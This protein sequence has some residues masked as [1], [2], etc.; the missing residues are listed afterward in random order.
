MSSLNNFER[1][2]IVGTIIGS[3]F[4]FYLLAVDTNPAAPIRAWFIVLGWILLAPASRMIKRKNT[5][6]ALWFSLLIVQSISMSSWYFTKS[7]IVRTAT[8]SFS[9][10]VSMLI[11]AGMIV[12]L[13]RQNVKSPK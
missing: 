10:L 4:G 12:L 7:S 11:V 6:L 5:Y 8:D 3:L 13:L 9:P 1:W 2:C